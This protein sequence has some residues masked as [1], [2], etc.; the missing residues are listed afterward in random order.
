MPLDEVES[1]IRSRLDDSAAR[2]VFPSSVAADHWLREATRMGAR[3]AIARERFMSWDSFKETAVAADLAGKRPASREL[4]LV[5]CA[6]LLSRNAEKPFLKSVV[7][8]EHRGSWKP[9]APALAASLPATIRLGDS[10]S[11]SNPAIADYLALRERYAAFLAS[12]GFYEPSWESKRFD[13][14]GV[15]WTIFFPELI[16]DFPEFEAVLLARPESEVRILRD[17]PPRSG[18]L[19]AHATVLGEIRWVL[20]GIGRAIDS[21]RAAP[22]EIAVT[23]PGFPGLKPYIEREAAIFGIPADFRSGTSLAEYPAGRFFSL[24]AAASESGCAFPDLRDLLCSG[25]IPW[26]EREA[27]RELVEFGLEYTVLCPWKEGARRVDPWLASFRGKGGRWERAESLYRGLSAQLAEFPKARG[28]PQLKAAWSAMSHSLMDPAEFPED[29]DLVFARCV[30]TMDELARAQREAGFDEAPWAFSL[31]LQSLGAQRYLPRSTPGGVRFYDYRVSAGIRPKLHYVMNSSQQS[32]DARSGGCPFLREDLRV[33][34]SLEERD[35]SEDFIRRYAQSGDEVIFSCSDSGID[36]AQIPHGYFL[37]DGEG[38]VRPPQIRGPAGREEE[39][40]AGDSSFP[41][42]ISRAQR[43]GIEAA[44]RSAFLPTGADYRSAEGTAWGL[45][46]LES[47]V[48]LNVSM[49]ENYRDCPFAWF[50]GKRLR[51]WTDESGISSFDARFRGIAVHA[52]LQRLYEAVARMGPMRTALL[53]EYAAL[54]PAAMEAAIAECE[55]ERGSFAGVVLRAGREGTEEV[56][57]SVLESDCA[58]FEG[59]RVFGVEMDIEGLDEKIGYV[60]AGRV[61]RL[62]EGPDGM[63]IVDYKTGELKMSNYAPEGD[64]GVRR[65]LQMPAYARLLVSKGRAVSGVL[66]YGVKEMAYKAVAADALPPFL[67]KAKP[68]MSLAQ[69]GA[70]GERF[71]QTAR[72][73]VEGI[74][75]GNFM[76]ADPAERGRVCAGCRLRPICREHY[77]VR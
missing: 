10:G 28:F 69:L 16:D 72:A 70:A 33:A 30:A 7:P 56:M 37:G 57:R 35:C 50:F 3:E 39:F 54:V 2:F 12:R 14:R 77:Q 64:D 1:A 44:S 11:R 26:R 66:L 55:R 63:W 75:T 8:P 71:A 13:P 18:S 46:A 52:A 58:A 34:L 76:T 9:F 40:W 25:G 36:G 22:G 24:I 4:R 51:A 29:L 53:G 15:A 6:D 23:V 60:V 43:R 65:D 48:S 21:G 74:R 59:C 49:I 61:D 47:V 73:V 41:D 20:E 31:F 62:M 38:S 5:F 68:Q 19:V 42:R 45:R 17:Q 32:L 67:S 27:A